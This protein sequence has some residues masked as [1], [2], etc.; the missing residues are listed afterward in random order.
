MLQQNSPNHRERSHYRMEMTE[1]KPKCTI[2]I[3]VDFVTTMH[4]P[5][6]GCVYTY[7]EAARYVLQETTTT[8]HSIAHMNFT[9]SVQYCI[10]SS[11]AHDMSP[12]NIFPTVQ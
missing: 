9:E 8:T 10:Y 2:I 3:T 4:A 6:Y 5:S 11:H 7:G 1:P 12:P